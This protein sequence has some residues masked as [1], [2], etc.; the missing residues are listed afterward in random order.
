MPSQLSENTDPKSNL[1]PL[2][3]H[4]DCFGWVP[5][6][7]GALSLDLTGSFTNLF[8]DVDRHS[9]VFKN[10]AGLSSEHFIAATSLSTVNDS[11]CGPDY[12]RSFRY[13]FVGSIHEPD[14]IENFIKKKE[15]DTNSQIYEILH[16]EGALL[17]TLIIVSEGSNTISDSEIIIL[18]RIKNLEK[19][20]QDYQHLFSVEAGSL[21]ELA[22]KR[23][24]MK[25]KWVEIEKNILRLP[26]AEDRYTFR[27]E[28]FLTRDG[29]LLL[30]DTTDSRFKGAYFMDGEESDYRKN[31]PIHRLFKSAMNF[32]KY[33]FHYNYHHDCV[34]DTYLP[35]SNLH[36]GK[37]KNPGSQYDF[38]RVFRHQMDAFVQPIIK[39]KREN[40]CEFRIDPIGVLSYAKAFV[41]TCCNNGLISSEQKAKSLEYLTIQESEINHL[42]R[43]HRSQLSAIIGQRNFIFLFSA[44]LA[45]LVAIVKIVGSVVN[46]PKYDFS[47]E[48]SNDKAFI[49]I[50][51]LGLCTLII[52]IILEATHA[53]ILRKEY[54]RKSHYRCPL[55]R[56]SN[57]EKQRFSIPYSTYLFY[58][59]C[60][61]NLGRKKVQY[62][63]LGF[64]LT[65]IAAII[66]FVLKYWT[67]G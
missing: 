11:K 43:H 41:A 6:I 10:Y 12:D 14:R 40:F 53:R 9:V 47:S 64:V 2:L 58:Q 56:D 57:L 39:L 5:T 26:G 33:L 54:R 25:N 42:T 65:S 29:I 60:K 17:G 67:L 37:N 44:V 23:G 62:A 32:I 48:A 22:A 27:F 49:A 13:F 28:V 24:E 34:H 3:G 1:L 8:G 59:D 30:K 36:P 7:G 45:L 4:Y 51:I 16:N 63:Y 15:L 52:W 61:L 35:A 50:G 18:K 46:I 55:L 20:K 31:V 38:S 21:K 66:Y 19:L